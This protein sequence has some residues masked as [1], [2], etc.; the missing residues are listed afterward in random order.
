MEYFVF[1]FKFEDLLE[2]T[3]DSRYRIQQSE[4]IVELDEKRLKKRLE[5]IDKTLYKTY[6]EIK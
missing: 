1:P 6:S 3:S 5:E 4:S 2:E